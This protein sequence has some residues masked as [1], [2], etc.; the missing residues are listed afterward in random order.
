MRSA[1][2][3]AAL[4]TLLGLEGVLALTPEQ[5]DQ[6]PGSP[7]EVARAVAAEEVVAADLKCGAAVCQVALRRIRGED[8]SLV[9]TEAF[10]APVDQPYLLDE[11]LGSLLRRSYGRK[12]RPGAPRLEV[13]AEDYKEFLRLRSALVQGTSAVPA[14]EVDDRWDAL[15]R[16]SPRFVEGWVHQAARLR[17]RYYLRRDPADLERA[18]AALKRARK[19]APTDPRPLVTLFEV[20]L[21]GDRI[22]VAE[23]ALAELETLQRADPAVAVHR[24]QLLERRGDSQAALALMR[25]A[26]RR[27]PS[28]H[29]LF[30]LADMEQRLGDGPAAR[31]D[32]QRALERFPGAYQGLALLAQIELAYGSPDE[33]RRIFEELVRR[34]PDSAGELT[35]LGT[36]YMLLRRW[37]DA[38]RAFR[39][40]LALE[41]QAPY[42]YL[43]LAD[44]LLLQGKSDDA[45]DHYSR[46]LE[47]TQAAASSSDWQVL[48]LRSQAL[49]HLGEKRQAVEA[50]QRV[51]LLAQGNS[52]AAY[53]AALVYAVVGD[54]ASALVN[55]DKAIKQGIGARWFSFPWFDPLR[56]TPEF[57]SALAA[58][59]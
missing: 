57:Q 16:S 44:V 6:V 37:P 23:D 33:A 58:A 35:N 47:L 43:N 31:R 1:A 12:Q 26:A 32:A 52:Q 56:A 24:A 22:D 3:A 20:G 10:E 8:G 30:R 48:S 38:E 5:V 36:A 49:A 28:Y 55:A 34:S 40:A 54:Q 11:A 45:R 13:G 15:L 19:L 27:R 59:P 21:A 4:R 14:D 39:K 7:V 41:P 25:D 18:F 51:L 9:W 17:N 29:N 42:T 50:T 2:H 53:E 46:L